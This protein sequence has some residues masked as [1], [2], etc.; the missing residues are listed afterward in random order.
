[1]SAPK[2]EAEKPT[3]SETILVVEDAAGVR[4][5]TQRMLE[6][7]GYNL[8]VAPNGQAALE[9]ANRY[10]DPIH[11]LLTDVVMPGLS[12]KAVAEQLTS[13]RPDL[14]VLFMSGYTE[15]AIAHHGMLDPYIFL[16]QKPFSAQ[17]LAHKV[18]E[19]LDADQEAESRPPD[20]GG[21]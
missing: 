3:G 12:G 15:E 5:L 7:W 20:R 13:T 9:L 16:L 1:V 4:D 2:V 10:P 6:G 11:L 17:E 14:K 18:R 19:V 21:N 8:L